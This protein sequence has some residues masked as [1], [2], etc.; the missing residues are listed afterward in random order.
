MK[1][2]KRQKEG[3]RSNWRILKLVALNIFG[4]SQEQ[5]KR[6]WRLNCR[7]ESG[8]YSPLW[9]NSERNR[10]DYFIWVIWKRIPTQ[11]RKFSNSNEKICGLNWRVED[12]VIDLRKNWQTAYKDW[13]SW[14]NNGFGNGTAGDAPLYG[15][16]GM[17]SKYME[18]GASKWLHLF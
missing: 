6:D 7:Y 2:R 1:I 8:Y 4:C 17:G 3:R 15:M 14:K 11:R 9:D 5:K 13:V 18:K 10:W 16:R 12:R